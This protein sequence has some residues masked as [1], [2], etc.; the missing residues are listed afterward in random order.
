MPSNA[1]IVTST[2]NTPLGL[3]DSPT[4]FDQTVQ[5][6]L[7]IK[8]KD[9]HSIVLLIDNSTQPITEQ[10]AAQLRSLSHA[11][12]LVGDRKICNHFNRWGIKGAGESYMLL[13]ALDALQQL[14]SSLQRIFKISGRYQ[15]S[16]GFDPDA[17]R[18]QQ[19]QFCF[20]RMERDDFGQLFLHTRMWSACGKDPAC[21]QQLVR[22]SMSHML[23]H[24]VTIEVA[25]AAN[26]DLTRLTQF[27][28]I[29]CEGLIAPWNRLIE[30]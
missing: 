24:S 3:I 21:M 4:R 20:K 15:L 29:H 7:S 25:T 12:L 1:W 11:L 30:D 18:D 9:P 2:I 10:Q 26:I 6:L 13:V 28:K 5:T 8:S 16:Q 14:P 17:Y 23:A 27:D 22:N 19:G